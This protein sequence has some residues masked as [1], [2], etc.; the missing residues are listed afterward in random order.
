MFGRQVTLFEIFGFRVKL[1]LSWA[2]LALLIAWSLA[3]GLFPTLYEGLTVATY[4]WMAIVGVI[5]VLISL[6][7]HELSHSLVAR[8]F[9]L[10]IRGITLFLFGGVAE[11]QEEPHSAKVECL[12]AIAC[13]LASGMLA[14]IF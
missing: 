8:R 4:W 10:Q 14:L 1:D 9:G 12:M 3:Q 6:V 2:F 7:V 13:T 5:G 11:M